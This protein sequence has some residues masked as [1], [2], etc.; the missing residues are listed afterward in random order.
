MGLVLNPITITRVMAIT[1]RLI[2]PTK[3]SMFWNFT[4]N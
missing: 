3:M 2:I 4:K 1:Y